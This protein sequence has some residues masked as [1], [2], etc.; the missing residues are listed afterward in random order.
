MPCLLEY[1]ISGTGTNY[2]GGYFSAGTY[3]GY[4]YYTGDTYTIYYSTGQTQWCLATSLGDPTCLLFG[5]SP[6][7][8][9]CPDLCD[10]LFGPGPC[11][12]PTPTPTAACNID[13][14][15]LFDCEVTV[16]PTVTPTMTPTVTPTVTPSSTNPCGGVALVVSGVTYTPTPTPTPTVTPTQ[17]ASIL[18]PC[19]YNGLVIF[20]TLDDYIRCANSK[21]FRDCSSGFIYSTTDVVLNPTGGTPVVD[22]VYGAT[23]NGNGI[24]VTY[25]GVVDNISG[26]DTVTLNIEYG[27]DCS[28][29][30]PIPSQTP[31]MTPTMTPTVTPSS[32]PSVCCEYVVTNLLFSANTFNTTNCSNGVPQTNNIG[33]NSIITIKSWT[34]PTGTNINVVFVD[35]PCITPTPTP[36]LTPTPSSTTP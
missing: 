15:G 20:N 30:L 35:C 31:T 25:L 36:T 23:I 13:F 8:S 27:P 26:T 6:C 21:Q 1:C 33:G 28:P 16:T 34:V 14:D 5:K 22:Y 11:P 4:D 10:E 19:N 32:T 24:C 2:D 29:C 9:L 7:S 3:D 18:R 17:S 12:S